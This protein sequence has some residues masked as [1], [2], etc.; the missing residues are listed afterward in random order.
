MD[1]TNSYKQNFKDYQDQLK[2]VGQSWMNSVHDR[3]VEWGCDHSCVDWCTSS[4][5]LIKQCDSCDCP[6][7]YQVTGDTRSLDWAR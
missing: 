4:C 3:L 7:P 5:D 2:N 1:V 6:S